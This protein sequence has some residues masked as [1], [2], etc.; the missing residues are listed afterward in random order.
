MTDMEQINE[1]L[2][3]DVREEHVIPALEESG[4]YEL[5]TKYGSHPMQEDADLSRRDV[6][7]AVQRADRGHEV[8]ADEI[9]EE[10]SDKVSGIS[11]STVVMAE[12][13][14]A[15]ETALSVATTVP[16]Q[17]QESDAFQMD[18]SGGGDPN[19][20]RVMYGFY[21]GAKAGMDRLGY[22]DVE[23]NVDI[24]LESHVS[25]HGMRGVLEFAIHRY[26]D[27]LK[28]ASIRNESDM[29][30]ITAA[31]LQ[32][33]ATECADYM[34]EYPDQLRTVD[35]LNLEIGDTV[36][37]GVQ[38]SDIQGLSIATNVSFDDVVGNEDLIDAL[39]GSKGYYKA[40]S[41]EHDTEWEDLD[42]DERRG[43]MLEKVLWYDPEERAN[44]FG[45]FPTSLLATGKPG[46]GKTHTLKAAAN[47]A[48]ERAREMDK[49]LTINTLESGT[50]HSKY[51]G[52]SAQNLEAEFDK[53]TSPDTIGILYIEDAESIFPARSDSSS[54]EDSK[55]MNTLL[56]RL[57][58][59][60]GDEERGNYLV[61][62][63]TNHATDLDPAVKSRAQVQVEAKGPTEQEHYEEIIPLLLE[64]NM[65]QDVLDADD[66]GDLI[67]VDDW[68]PLAETAHEYEFSGRALDN[69]T[70]EIAADKSL[71]PDPRK[72]AE[73]E[74]IEE[75]AELILDAK[76][77]VDYDDI[78]EALEEKKEHLDWQEER[79]R[80]ERIEDLLE[81]ERI[82]DAVDER[83]EEDEASEDTED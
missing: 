60:E 35:G 45:A 68:E 77:P 30:R 75:Q 52:E 27:T 62:M 76:R 14:D 24:D 18:A 13:Y 4:I 23:V 83:L 74:S 3:D 61:I 81:Q 28:D 10:L 34:Q 5:E 38:S 47:Y 67:Q 32:Q 9:Y 64:K 49:P 20:F 26:I 78:E 56:N 51:H 12:T 40:M 57:Q 2:M 15:L 42:P 66:Q 6:Y 71:M 16:Q 46:T 8:D 22:T 21:A 58:G 54:E 43:G 73:A 7:E 37:E 44:P 50:V 69:L 29:H 59:L 55:T 1:D 11:P 82:H 31:Y 63:T 41:D 65:F 19:T 70:K 80:E 53:V 79:E 36:I 39:R 48:A 33:V 25:E 72:L 17:F